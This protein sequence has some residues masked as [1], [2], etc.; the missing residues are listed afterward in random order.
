MSIKK[1]FPVY[2]IS[3]IIL[4]FAPFATTA[5]DSKMSLTVIP[6]FFQLALDPGE[7]FKSSVKVA[8]TNNYDLNIYTSL[9]NFKA[10]GDEGRGKLTPIVG[11]GAEVIPNTLAQWI[12][13]SEGPFASP[14][15]NSI[16]IPFTVTIPKDA[17][18]GGHYAAILIGTKPMGQKMEGPTIEVASY[19]STLLFIRVSGQVVEQ[20]GIREFTAE[21]SFYQKPE[22]NFTLRFENRG[23][24]HLQP[25]GEIVI[26]NMWGKERGKIKVN[27]DTEFGYVLPDTVRKFSF[28]WKGEDSIL[29]A[30][31]Y[32]AVATLAFGSDA[33]QNVSA[34]TYFWVIPVKPVLAIL[35]G[36][37]LFLWLLLWS[38][39][40]YIRKALGAYKNTVEG[41]AAVNQAV[42]ARASAKTKIKR[43]MRERGLLSLVLVI[44]IVGVVALAFYFTQVLKSERD[45]EMTIRR[46]D[47]TTKSVTKENNQTQDSSVQDSSGL[48]VVPANESSGFDI[49]K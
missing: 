9:M 37:I 42:P 3:I 33:R 45:Y 15:E 41:A 36:I 5:A 27:Q 43:S 20:G 13:I 6:P 18:P 10:E 16:E 14:K 30:G 1:Q 11:S 26:S 29:E 4:L 32:K 47:G 49:K 23:N 24:V 44:L 35:G 22:I 31:R 48:K 34:A 46:N 12:K 21:K 38:I 19:I 2:I 39:K 40:A 25:Q 17:P 7:T 28:N 8:N